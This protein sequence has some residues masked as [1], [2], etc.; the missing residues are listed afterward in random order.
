MLMELWWLGDANSTVEDPGTMT[1]NNA[2]TFT[3]SFTVTDA[4]GLADPTPATRVITVQSGA[5]VIPHTNWSLVSVD[6]QEL[7]GENGAG[8]NAFDGNVATRWHTNGWTVEPFRTSDASSIWGEFTMQ[9]A[10]G[11]CRIR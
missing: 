11:P 7:A 1:F 8:G 3:V 4:L 5:S 6:S 10:F 2:G 9:T